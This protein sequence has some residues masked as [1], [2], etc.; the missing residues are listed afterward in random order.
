MLSLK[1]IIRSVAVRYRPR[2]TTDPANNGVLP[3]HDQRTI[4]ELRP[5][6]YYE[7][8]RKGYAMREKIE[9]PVCEGKGSG[10][11]MDGRGDRC[12]DACKGDGVANPDFVEMPTS[13]SDMQTVVIGEDAKTIEAWR[14]YEL[15][16]R[17]AWF[18]AEAND[19]GLG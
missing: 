16:N 18:E 4:G 15:A 11:W 9:C 8:N 7:V 14:A 1:S 6:L 3:Y 19:Y 10:D 17:D 12:C 5:M 13:Q 2:P